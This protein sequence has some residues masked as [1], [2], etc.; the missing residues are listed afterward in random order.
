MQNRSGLVICYQNASNAGG[1][2]LVV[3]DTLVVECA[4]GDTISV[5]SSSGNCIVDAFDEARLVVSLLQAIP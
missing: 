2:P 5:G 4:Q 3:S 1:N